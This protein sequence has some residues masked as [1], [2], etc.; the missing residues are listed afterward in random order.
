MIPP[1]LFGLTEF[2]PGVQ[3]S[4]IRCGLSHF[5]ALTNRGE[6]FV[7]GK[8]IQGCP[9]GR[10]VLPMEGDYSWGARGHGMWCGSHGDSR[11]VPHLNL[12]LDPLE[13]G[14]GLRTICL[15]SKGSRGALNGAWECQGPPCPGPCSVQPGAGRPEVPELVPAPTPTQPRVRHAVQM[16]PLSAKPRAEWPWQVEDDRLILAPSRGH[17]MASGVTSGL[18]RSY[19]LSHLCVLLA[20]SGQPCMGGSFLEMP[21]GASL[22]PCGP[23]AVTCLV[24]LLTAWL[25]RLERPPREEEWGQI[26]MG[27]GLWTQPVKA[28]LEC[29]PWRRKT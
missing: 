22:G 15:L 19:S 24:A 10:P 2:N 18:Q 8:N 14:P 26:F 12:L 28:W 13:P 1:T 7:W 3:V 16:L 4:C 23:T 9:G 5:A 27:Q 20:H 21:V 11:Q 29:S 17:T 6:L 25:R